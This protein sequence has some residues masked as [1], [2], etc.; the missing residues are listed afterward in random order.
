MQVLYKL[1]AFI[2]TLSFRVLM[3]VL[4]KLLAINLMSFRVISIYTSLSVIPP[5]PWWA[6]LEFLMQVLY[7]LLAI[8]HT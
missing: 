6:V 1:L 8:I 3:Q 4:Y 7:K 5:P 2:H